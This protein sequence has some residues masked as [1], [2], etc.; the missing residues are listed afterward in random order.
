[1]K[2]MATLYFNIKI[3]GLEIGFPLTKIGV[4]W[5]VEIVDTENNHIEIT[6]PVG[7]SSI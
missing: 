6:A 2:I 3:E 7:Q 1:M 4:N 5:V